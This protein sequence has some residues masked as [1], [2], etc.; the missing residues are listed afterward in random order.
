MELPAISGDSTRS[1][2]LNRK[3][4]PDW[5]G[6]AA[7]LLNPA[8]GTVALQ[9]IHKKIMRAKIILVLLALSCAAAPRVSNA[10]AQTDS[11]I[12]TYWAA[13]KLAVTKGDKSTIG[14]MTQFPVKMPYGVP[15][16]KTKAQLS[17]RY[18]D[19]F[20][21]QADAVKC[22]AAAAPKVDDN[23]KNQF[24]VGCKDKAGNEVVVYG[25]ARK[26]GV[27]KLIFLDNINE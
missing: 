12:Q 25:F 24:T 2:Q 20:K 26:R 21:V 18:R 10:G 9:S 23:D 22:F 7:L 16:I 17:S 8:T 6:A 15:A 19:L 14:S 13:F 4:R 3:Q 27:W 5:T 11:S 1:K